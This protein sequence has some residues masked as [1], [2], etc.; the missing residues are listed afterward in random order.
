MPEVTALERLNQ[1]IQEYVSKKYNVLGTTTIQQIP[2]DFEIVYNLV[3]INPDPK[4]RQVYQAA[5]AQDFALGKVALMQ[6]AAAALISFDWKASGRVDDGSNKDV[7]RY[8]SVGHMTDL[9]GERRTMVAEKEIDLV[10]IQRELWANYEKKATTGEQWIGG[11]KRKLREDETTEWIRNAVIRD[12]IQMKKHQLARAQTGAIE[13]VISLML[14]LK[15]GYTTEE[16]SKPFVVPSLRFSPDTSDPEVKRFY[17]ALKAGVIEQMYPQGPALG[18]MTLQEDRRT[19]DIIDIGTGT[20]LDEGYQ[21]EPRRSL[22]SGTTKPEEK[23]APAIPIEQTSGGEPSP[24]EQEAGGKFSLER[25]D[26]PPH[27]FEVKWN[28]A[29]SEEA[30]NR[31]LRDMMKT[32]GK[33]EENY[34]KPLAKFTAK[35]REEMFDHL[36]GLIRKQETRAAK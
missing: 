12:L 4:G 7:V 8:R 26:A 5:G 15:S 28:E 14:G 18:G 21:D 20:V 3:Q 24:G 33:T 36:F 6:I 19:G 30:K 10:A 35:E 11:K 13:R 2:R 22:P 23:P 29:D 32:V 17:L 34:V 9:S 27:I 25:E 16:L 1:H 31:V